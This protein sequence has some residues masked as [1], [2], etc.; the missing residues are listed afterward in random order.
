MGKKKKQTG[1][2]FDFSALKFNTETHESEEEIPRLCTEQAEFENAEAM[3]DRLDYSKDYFCFVPGNFVFGDF[4]E[5]LVFK[6]RPCTVR[7]VYNYSRHG[8]G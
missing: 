5:A 1:F 2:S 4:I 3:A 6:K 7:N 8:P